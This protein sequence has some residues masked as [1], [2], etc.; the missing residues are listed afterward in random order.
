MQTRAALL[1]LLPMLAL[2]GCASTIDHNGF[3]STYGG[4]KAEEGLSN[5]MVYEGNKEKLKNVDS[6]IVDD[7]KILAETVKDGE[8]GLSKADADLMAKAFEE[9]LK[10][11][12]GKNY[13]I[14]DKRGRN[15]LTVRTALVQLEPHSPEL[16]V[17]SYA[18]YSFVVQGGIW[19]ATGDNVISGTTKF[20]GEMVDSRTGEQLYAIVDKNTGK[21]FQVSA[22]LRKWGHSEKAFQMWARK[23]RV[24]LDQAKAEANAPEKPAEAPKKVKKE[25]EI[26]SGEKTK[27]EGSSNRLFFNLGGKKQSADTEA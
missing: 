18:P 17:L 27:K 8:K 26:G 21:K 3:L 11:E 1:L 9:A 23:M 16:Y 5:A 4:L 7:V 19:A 6:I 24:Y 20:Q 15:T 2:G 10:K 14:T 22:G 25:K 12:F 13:K